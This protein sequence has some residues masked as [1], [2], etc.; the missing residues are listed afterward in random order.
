MKTKRYS[1]L[2]LMG[3]ISTDI[4]QGALPALLPFLIAEHGFSIASA[5][6]LIFASNLVSSI[7]QPV[8]GHLGDKI[9]KPQLM[10]LG[11]LLASGGISLMGFMDSYWAMFFCAMGGGVGVAL[12][13]PEASKL[14]A[15]VSGENKGE[16]MSLFAVGGNSGFAVGPMVCSAL[17]L[18]FGIHG[19]AAF[20]I[21]GVVTAAILMAK[22][23]VIQSAAHEQKEIALAA[24]SGEQRD[25][26]PSFMKVAMA[27]FCR[28]IVG[29]C[30]N[31][32][33]P[34]FWVYVLVQSAASG[35]VQLT[36]YSATGAVATLVGGR[37]ADRIGFKRVVMIC[38]IAAVPLLFALAM[39]RSTLVG[40]I[41]IVLTGV[42][43]NGCHSTFVVMG[44]GFLP[45]RLGLASGVLYGLTVSVGGMAAPGVGAIADHAGVP[46][47]MLT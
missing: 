21:I 35:N 42:F 13:H 19:T 3:H 31:T 38:S 24:Q 7:V 30:L 5:A 29:T 27:M 16:G 43:L 2:L 14:A 18:A 6:G 33:I 23:K 4:N 26:W 8:F 37:L 11:M 17:M 9:E 40:G 20:I 25:D 34:L 1:Y 15:H 39:T 36:I 41:L 32:F 47:A 44:Q 10:C 12:F 45:N 22:V 28:S 46:A